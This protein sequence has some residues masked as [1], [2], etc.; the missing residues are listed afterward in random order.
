MARLTF[1]DSHRGAQID[2]FV[3]AASYVVAFAGVMVGWWR[4]GMGRDGVALAVVVAIGL[5]AM[6]V[7]SMQFVRTATGGRV[8]TKL[9][10]YGIIGAA[11][12]T[13]APALRIASIV[14]V[15]FRR[16]AAA[17]AFLL[18][19]LMTADRAV[20]PALIASALLIILATV[21]VYHDEIDRAIR[22]RANRPAA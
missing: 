3:D 8:D 18:V 1:S 11:R 15:L 14:F 9:I 21:V 4:Q 10:E 7:W 22:V 12:T 20:Y 5:P 17:L 16:E 2:T 13:G 6:M 19:S